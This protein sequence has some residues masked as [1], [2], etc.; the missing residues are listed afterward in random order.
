MILFL[1]LPRLRNSAALIVKLA[2]ARRI[3]I[4]VLTMC[5]ARVLG[6]LAKARLARL[7]RRQARFVL[8]ARKAGSKPLQKTD[9]SACIVLGIIIRT[10]DFRPHDGWEIFD[11]RH[12]RCIFNWLQCICLRGCG[13]CR[14]G[15]GRRRLEQLGRRLEVT[16]FGLGFHW[17]FSCADCIGHRIGGLRRRRCLWS[18]R[19]FGCLRR[20]RRL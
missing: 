12:A 9:R 19:C 14:P 8:T 18:S 11:A 15:L 5:T 3:K 20:L 13:S 7:C 16:V 6:R 17:R 1:A 10:L 2:A 4:G